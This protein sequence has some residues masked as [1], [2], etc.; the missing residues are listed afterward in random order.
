VVST[1]WAPVEK[2]C[3]CPRRLTDRRASSR[4]IS[5]KKDKREIHLSN[6]P[7]GP[8]YVPPVQHSSTAQPSYGVQT[9]IGGPWSTWIVGPVGQRDD[10][11]RK[12]K[13]SRN[14]GGNLVFF[15]LRRLYLS[16]GHTHIQRTQGLLVKCVPGLKACDLLLLLL[17]VREKGGF[18]APLSPE[19][20]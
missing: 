10:P 7:R 9:H 15:R 8:K 3:A 14:S 18:F 11:K 6:K 19:E 16:Q 4:S 1:I 12:K 2:S 5:E 17:R 20:G 13:K